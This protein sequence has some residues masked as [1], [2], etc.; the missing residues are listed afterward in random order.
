MAAPRVQNRF[1]AAVSHAA[2]RGRA[3]RRSFRRSHIEVKPKNEGVCAIVSRTKPRAALVGD[4]GE[5][6]R[7]V[8]TEAAGIQ[9]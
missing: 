3:P 2:S 5:A 1:A 9:G 8:R 7:L 4:S 6:E